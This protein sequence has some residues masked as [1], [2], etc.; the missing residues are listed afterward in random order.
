MGPIDVCITTIFTSLIMRYQAKLR[1]YKD[2]SELGYKFNRE[3]LEKL[4]EESEVEL[5]IVTDVLYD[6]STF[7]P[8]LNLLIA[9]QREEKYN[10]FVFEAWWRQ[11]LRRTQAIVHGFPQ[12]GKIFA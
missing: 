6:I 8:F 10:W 5:D 7:V 3:K 9:A 11:T 1:I 2:V 12:G 4:E